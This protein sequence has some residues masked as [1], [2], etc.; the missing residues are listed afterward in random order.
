LSTGDLTAPTFSRATSTGSPRFC[1][2]TLSPDLSLAQA[3]QLWHPSRLRMLRSRVQRWILAALAVV[4]VVCLGALALRPYFESRI[5]T[6]I[7]A[8]AARLGLVARIDGVRLGLWPP[9]RL[10]GVAL[11]FK[12]SWRLMTEGVEVWWPGRI[13]LV[14]GQAVLQGRAGIKATAKSTTWDVLSIAREDFRIALRNPQSGLVLSRRIG[15]HDEALWAVE[16]KDLAMDR[17]LDISR[18]DK[19]LLH[20]G[21]MS[22]LLTLRTPPEVVHFDLDLTARSARLPALAGDGSKQPTLGEPTDL[23]VQA[24]GSW[25]RSG[26]ALDIPH[27]S[28]TLDTAAL[29]GSLAV[30][31]L[32]TDATVDLSVDVERVDFARLLRSSGLEAPKSLGPEVVAGGAGGLGS[33]SLAASARGRISDPASFVV[34][35]KLDFT[36][37][38]RLP[39]RI[40]RLRGDFVHEVALESGAIRAIDVSPSSP[41]FIPL[42]EVPPLFRRALLIAEDAGFYGHPGI[43]LREVPA[44]LLTDWSRGGAARG[45]STITQQLA[46]NLFLSRDKQLGRKLQELS[47]TL[48]LESALS[49]DRILEIYLNVIQ[50]GPGL[51]GLRPAARAYFGREP[52]ELTPAQTAFLVSLIPGPVKYQSSFRH[53]TPGPGLRRLVDGLLAKLRSVDALT[54]DEYRQA[55]DEEIVIQGREASTPDPSTP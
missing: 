1:P 26:G 6:E 27:L 43:D 10:T 28:A 37:P 36:P 19:T 39:S 42:G 31:D 8:E 14:V 16:A 38:Q 50:W 15:P 33:A 13:R 9:L 34:T 48:L 11:S 49:K 54:E 21:T 47:L 22:G 40:V 30:R 25:K 55:L 3:A 12:E 52:G 46:K 51:Y 18:F 5:R 7:V 23:A 4:L 41:D 24:A 45:A 53:G 44:A 17:L 35:Q 20:S 29:S 2:A 32:N